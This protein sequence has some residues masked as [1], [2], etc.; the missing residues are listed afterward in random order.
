M[1]AVIKKIYTYRWI[2]R[3][4]FKTIYLNFKCLPFKQAI[5]LPILL[6]KP[7]LLALSGRIR[8]ETKQ[9]SFGMIQLGRNKVSFYQS[10]GIT[11]ENKGL[12]VF[13]GKASICSGG[14]L[15][16]NKTG[17]L[18][19]GN[20]FTSTAELK[21]AC[22]CSI[23]IG[24]NVLVGWETKIFDTDFHRLTYL[25]GNNTKAYGSIVIGN[26]VWIANDCQI[27]KNTVIPDNCIIGTR[28]TLMTKYDVPSYS[29]IAGTSGK[30]I[31]T[32]CWL[33]ISNMTIEYN[34]SY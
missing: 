30:I 34:Y 33:D 26:N 7:R 32:G 15:S 3:S 11:I 18:T 20:N 29:M 12:I 17:A 1:K 31:K 23:T 21:I 5:H 25:N 14:C 9:I 10:T 19:I 6:Y 4:I 16:V 24:E 28:S 8:I 27:L 2:F 22:Y 13:K